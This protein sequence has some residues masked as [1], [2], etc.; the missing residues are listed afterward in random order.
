MLLTWA[1]SMLAAGGMIG[2]VVSQYQQG[3][4]EKKTPIKNTVENEV[5]YTF[6]RSDKYRSPLLKVNEIIDQ[7]KKT[8]DIAVFII[9]QDK[10]IPRMKKR[11]VK[12]RVITDGEQSQRYSKNAINA[13][14]N[15]G[16]PVKV[17]KHPGLMHL[18]IMI[19]DNKLFS[20]GSYNFTRSAEE[21]NDEVLVIIKSKK[22][23]NDW[24][25]KYNLMWN[26]EVNYTHYPNDQ[27]QRYA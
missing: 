6:T 26:D 5:E 25:D 2:Y 17:N 13:L 22:I 4:K 7:T 20:T 12:V 9:T 18:K 21:K 27:S 15:E 24:T 19:A 3:R 11:G 16:I 23:A 8:L 10:I 14:I 1:G